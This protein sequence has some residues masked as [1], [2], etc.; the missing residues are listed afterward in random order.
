MTKKLIPLSLFLIACWFVTPAEAQDGSSPIFARAQEVTGLAS[1][2]DPEALAK[3]KQALSDD[4]WYVRGVA[5]SALGKRG[6]SEAASLL[7]LIQ[8]KNWFV[9]DQAVAALAALGGS[10]DTGYLVALLTS[11]D[12]YARARAGQDESVQ[13]RASTDRAFEG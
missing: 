8:D 1:S 5:A 13:G 7:P 6:D 10:F 9:R 11:S 3:L 2:K 4:N 12:A